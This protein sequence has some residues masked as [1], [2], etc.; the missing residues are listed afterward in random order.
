M[1]ISPYITTKIIK[2][3]RY[4]KMGAKSFTICSVIKLDISVTHLFD[5]YVKVYMKSKA[6]KESILNDIMTYD[7]K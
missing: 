6:Q 3:I 5:A 2:M 7:M 4:G 1:R